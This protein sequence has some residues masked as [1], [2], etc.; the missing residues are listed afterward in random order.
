MALSLV[1]PGWMVHY[2]CWSGSPSASLGTLWGVHS[3][4]LPYT[5][6]K[7]KM[8]LGTFTMTLV[9]CLKSSIYTPFCNRE[10]VD[11]RGNCWSDKSCRL[12]I[13]YRFPL[14][15]PV[16]N[17]V[18][19]PHLPGWNHR[20]K[21]FSVSLK[22]NINIFCLLLCLTCPG[23]WGFR[24][25]KS[26]W[27]PKLLPQGGTQW[28]QLHRATCVLHVRPIGQISA[29]SPA[30]TRT[31]AKWKHK[32]LEQTRQGGKKTSNPSFW[33][34]SICFRSWHVHIIHKQQYRH[35]MRVIEKFK[36]GTKVKE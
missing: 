8:L 30:Q 6:P 28:W 7:L 11:K 20:N 19:G 34:I 5:P 16:E 26:K 35:F 10:K 21:S 31:K 33:Y 12:S 36:S 25:S 1:D 14:T 17:T 22:E 23:W 32:V 2:S 24:C 27:P 18:P 29:H 3:A 4:L 13:L 9:S 15:P